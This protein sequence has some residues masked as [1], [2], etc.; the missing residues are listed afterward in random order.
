MPQMKAIL[1]VKNDNYNIFESSIKNNKTISYK[2]KT[3]SLKDFN[4]GINYNN[5]N[6][7]ITYN[8]INKNNLKSQQIFIKNRIKNSQNNSNNLNLN[9]HLFFKNNKFKNLY[10]SENNYSTKNKKGT[11]NKDLNNNNKNINNVSQKSESLK[12]VN[13]I[14]NY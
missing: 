1:N 6:E 14:H 11:K 12:P 2:K 5:C 7:P 8:I 10:N 9:N 13:Q 3:N 4:N